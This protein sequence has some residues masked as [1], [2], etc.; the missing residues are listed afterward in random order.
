[1]RGLTL[2]DA[3]R[4]RGAN[5][6]FAA[7]QGDGD[8]LSFL[9]ARGYPT[10]DLEPRLEGQGADDITECRD[11][12]ET[13]AR[14]PSAVDMLV[15]D[16]YE[17][18]GDWQLAMRARCDRL[19]VIDDLAN[20]DH[21]CDLL[22]DQNLG[23]APADYASHVPAHCRVLTGPGFALLRP[24]FAAARSAS[25]ARRARA[26]GAPVRI[27]VSLGGVDEPNATCQVL[28]AIEST[29][30]G[31]S[32]EIVVLLGA[33]APWIDEVKALA[34]NSAANIQVRVGVSDVAELMKDSDLAIGAAGG[35]SWERCCL[36]LPAL[37]II[38]A[39]NQ[40]SG[41]RALE[42]AGAAVI[43]GELST[44]RD[45]L[46]A[47]LER[48][49]EDPDRLRRMSEASASVTDGLGVARVVQALE[50]L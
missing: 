44:F 48:L 14:L 22:L 42:S 45:R 15:C 26:G 34:T 13:L 27:L 33:G 11:A 5:C 21:D 47:E 35:S 23:R 50:E 43:L 16:H 28:E 39:D 40:R 20:R 25:L 37:L 46:C 8:M 3:L 7:R 17:L 30:V 4:E 2:A 38:L 36:G 49:H 29:P 24:Q 18:G 12:T 41:A 6:L 19:M 1:M 32:S 31:R 9:H 10:A